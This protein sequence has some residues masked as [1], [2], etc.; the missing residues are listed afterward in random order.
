M[1]TNPGAVAVSNIVIWGYGEIAVGMWVGCLSTL[2]PL[3]RKMFSLGSLGSSGAASK[4]GAGRSGSAFPSNAR[5]T[6]DQFSSKGDVEMGNMGNSSNG[7]KTSIK[8]DGNATA[9]EVN[10][11]SLSSDSESM[12]QILKEAN[13]YGGTGGGK[14]I[15]VSRQVQ[16]QRS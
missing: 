13:Q 7:F 10:R 8:S 5:R 9:A 14:G 4:G 1:L 6:Y 3:F 16:I 15:V 12:E 11:G 2:R